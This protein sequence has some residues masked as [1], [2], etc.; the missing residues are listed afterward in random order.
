MMLED[1]TYAYL[2]VVSDI[3]N[4]GHSMTDIRNGTYILERA[5]GLKLTGITRCSWMYQH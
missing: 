3:L 4:D 2:R 5:K 1:L